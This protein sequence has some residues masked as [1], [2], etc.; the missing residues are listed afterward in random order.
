[1]SDTREKPIKSIDDLAIE[2]QLNAVQGK[3]LETRVLSI[4]ESAKREGA[5]E[6]LEVARLAVQYYAKD[7]ELNDK[8]VILATTQ[9]LKDRIKQLKEGE[10]EIKMGKGPRHR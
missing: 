1:M 5:I 2:L 6:G 3:W 9:Y 4:I 8:E 7:S 10:G